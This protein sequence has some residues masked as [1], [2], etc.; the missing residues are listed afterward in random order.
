MARFP[1]LSLTGRSRPRRRRGVNLGALPRR[2][3]YLLVAGVL[4]GGCQSTDGTSAK[5]GGVG[6]RTVTDVTGT[7]VTVPRQPRRVITLS[8]LDLDC[9]LALG[10]RPVGLSAGRGQRG[11]P[12]YLA[13]RVNGVPVVGA[14]T[15]PVLDRLIALNPDLIL[16]GQVHDP[17]VLSQLR[18]IAP[19]VV[20]YRLGDDWKLAVRRIGGALGQD[21][22]AASVLAGYATSVRELSGRLGA[23][24]HA[25]VSI[26][27]WSPQG[28]SLIQQGL[29]GSD[30]VR[31]IG[32]R[33]PPGQLVASAGH[34]APV[35]LENLDQIDADWIFLGTLSQDGA[36]ASALRAAEAL[37]A[38]QRL[39]AVRQRRLVQ[40]DGATW[41]S[42][43]GPLAARSVLAD[44][45]GALVGASPA[46]RFPVSAA[47]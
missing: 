31:D 15:G 22:A 23:R 5:P 40:V 36:D 30:V 39:R 4:L 9:A 35:S 14:V 33:R 17:Q 41:T 43:G 12:R 42:L 27:R 16:A 44:V 20:T 6:A 3:A 19:T 1:L 21:S 18:Q 10:V 11:A 7:A 25:V 37:P 46:A 29:F 13:A 28:P 38:F 34:S 24:A 2:G 26:V 32:L 45:A 8:E 47:G